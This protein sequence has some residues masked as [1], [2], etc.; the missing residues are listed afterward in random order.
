VRI[1]IR[2]PL[3]LILTPLPRGN[4]ACVS[5]DDDREAGGGG[6]GGV[7][8]RDTGERGRLMVASKA[9]TPVAPRLVRLSVLS[10]CLA[11]SLTVC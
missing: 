3:V 5:V 8:S 2:P 7:L 11:L 1:M 9:G 6:G 4:L 10:C